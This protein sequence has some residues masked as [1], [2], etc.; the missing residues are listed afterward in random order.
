[1][2]LGAENELKETQQPS[3]PPG[4]NVIKDGAVSINE[5][6]ND[7]IRAKLYQKKTKLST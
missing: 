4:I 7:F 5:A 3:H 1:L 2:L 6:V